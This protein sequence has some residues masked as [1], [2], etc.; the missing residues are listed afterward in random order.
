MRFSINQ[1]SVPAYNPV[2]LAD[3]KKFLEISDTE[4]RHDL[5]I[6]NLINGATSRAENYTKQLFAQRLVTIN[7]DFFQEFV[8]LP[9]NPIVSLDTIKYY[10]S[11]DV[12]QTMATTDYDVDIYD[13]P[14]LIKIKVFP[15]IKNKL[16]AVQFNVTAG[17]TSGNSP[18]GSDMIPDAIKEAIKFNVYQTFMNR[19]EETEGIIRAFE[20]LLYNYRTIKL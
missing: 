12:L 5:M 20:N 14:P 17:Y 1:T 15:S 4:T 9:I 11:D 3:C 18:I 10:D 13:K 6:T 2:T 16:N 8:Y 7:S 19:G